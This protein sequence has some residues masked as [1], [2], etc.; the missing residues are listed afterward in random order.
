MIGCVGF[1]MIKR[2][3]EIFK[4]ILEEWSCEWR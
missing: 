4:F 1:D 2:V 3:I